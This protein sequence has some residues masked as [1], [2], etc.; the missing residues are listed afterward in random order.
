MQLYFAAYQNKIYVYQ[1]QRPPQ[2]LPLV[3]LILRPPQSETAKS[4]GGVLDRAFPH[5]MNYITVGD[6][7]DLEILLLAFDDGDIV[8]YYTHQIVQIIEA[9]HSPC[10][11][12]AGR[13]SLRP[14]F[15][16]S[17][18]SSAWGLAIHTQSRLIA[19]SSNRHDVTVFAFALAYG[20][21]VDRERGDCSYPSLWLGQSVLDLEKHF[22][23]RTRSWRVV[24]PIGYDGHNNPNNIPSIAFCDDSLGNADRVAAVDIN[25]NTWLLDIW[26]IGN[27]AILIKPNRSMVYNNT[28]RQVIWRNIGYLKDC[29][30]T[31]LGQTTLA[32]ESFCCPTAASNRL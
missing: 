25:G 32:G 27:P 4:T 28:G 5:Q 12:N 11:W 9:R 17:V 14:F 23:S 1:P 21:N 26:N 8:A 18:G 22:R 30:L 31:C 20:E 3:S 10:G 24:L 19:A 6:L 15:H 29:G 13:P 2:I 7:G 16:E